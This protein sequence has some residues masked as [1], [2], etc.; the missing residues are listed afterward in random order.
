MLDPFGNAGIQDSLGYPVG[1]CR[2]A[3]LVYPHE[4]HNPHTVEKGK[5]ENA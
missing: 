4:Y 1:S 5:F 3:I 2:Y